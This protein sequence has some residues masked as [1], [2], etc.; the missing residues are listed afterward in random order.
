MP[1]VQNTDKQ[2]YFNYRQHSH[3]EDIEVK[4]ALILLAA[5]FVLASILQAKCDT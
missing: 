4:R 3:L 5:L 1:N 2:Y